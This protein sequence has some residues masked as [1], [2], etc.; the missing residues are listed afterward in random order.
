MLELLLLLGGVVAAGTGI[1][2]W[3]NVRDEWAERDR[4]EAFQAAMRAA[5][6][7]SPLPQQRED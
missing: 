3:L 1:V 4:L 6:K 7:D 5:G 2:Y